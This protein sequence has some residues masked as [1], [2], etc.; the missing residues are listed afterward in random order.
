MMLDPFEKHLKQ[1]KKDMTLVKFSDA[2]S[3]AKT[4]EEQVELCKK[5]LHDNRPS[6][7]PPELGINIQ[8]QTLRSHYNNIGGANV[9]WYKAKTKI[10]AD[11]IMASRNPT[12]LADETKKKLVYELL[13][14]I[15]ADGCILFEE[16]RSPEFLDNIYYAYVGV[17][18]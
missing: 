3:Q 13:Q 5:F 8:S 18:K 16:E 17:V 7:V 2:V 12:L 1:A 15:L 14:Q 6:L 9:K 11:L 10:D 4:I